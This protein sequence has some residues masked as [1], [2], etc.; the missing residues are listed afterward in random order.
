MLR[1]AAGF[2][3][4]SGLT[5]TVDERIRRGQ[6]PFSACNCP[7]R[8]SHFISGNP[9]HTGPVTTLAGKG[10]RGMRHGG[11][12][13]NVTR[14]TGR[15]E[16]RSGLRPA[17]PASIA[18]HS[19]CRYGLRVLL[20]PIEVDVAHLRSANTTPYGSRRMTVTSSQCFR[21]ARGRRVDATSMHEPSL[22]SRT[23]ASF[24]AA[25]SP[26]GARIRIPPSLRSRLRGNPWRHP[27]PPA[28]P[29]PARH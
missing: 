9:P 12:G 14:T 28:P 10:I 22:V 23:A 29:S 15:G 13:R 17:G 5:E 1:T 20:S 26:R 6:D 2:G 11:R 16:R 18:N 4:P 3:V 27:P 21:T 24:S 7:T 25:R 8:S 19:L